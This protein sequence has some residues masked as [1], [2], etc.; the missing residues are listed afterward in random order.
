MEKCAWGPD[1][2]ICKEE[3]NANRNKNE[4]RGD[5]HHIAQDYHDEALR[6]RRE[7]EE[8]MEKLNDKYGLDYYSSSDSGSDWEEEPRYETLE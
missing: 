6:K 3:E 4:T 5:A 1:C 8:R 2:P 7:W